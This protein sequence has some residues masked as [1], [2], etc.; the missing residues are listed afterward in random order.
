[1]ADTPYEIGIA[2]ADITP[3]LGVMLAGY[4]S[5]KDGADEVGHPLRAEALACKDTAGGGWVLVT[6]DVVGYPIELVER[7]RTVA[8]KATGLAPEAICISATHTHS[9]PAAVRAYLAELS[10]VDHQ[11]RKDILEPQLAQVIIDAW[12]ASEPGTF[13]VAMTKAPD[14]ASNRRVLGDD[15]TATNDWQDPDGKHTGYFDPSVMLIGVRRPGGELAALLVNYGVHPVTLG[16]R[17]LAISADYPGYMK[18]TIEQC[19]A[20]TTALYALA[21]A[22]N[23]NPRDCIEVGPD[24][25]RRMGEALG[26]IVCQ[27]IPNLEPVGAGP[28][29]SHRQPWTMISQR[30]WPEES[31]RSKGDEITSEIMALKAGDLAIA[32]VPGELFS[33]YV[34]MIRKVSPLPHTAVVSIANDSTGYFPLDEAQSQGGLEIRLRA[35]DALEGPLM[36]HT[37]AALKAVAD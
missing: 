35:A 10:D 13:E 1:M 37:T 8:A 2:T 3:P 24:H 29:A 14:L 7:V 30:Q 25:P 16:P 26:E 22:G 28:V 33:E 21:G 11:Y 27:A 18:D 34:A 5:R 36:E 23:I 9:G 4:G 17:S 20:G 6:S 19:H 12:N 32:T 15:G 31:G